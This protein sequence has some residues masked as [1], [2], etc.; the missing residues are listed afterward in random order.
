MNVEPPGEYVPTAHL[1]AATVAEPVP[2]GQK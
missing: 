1:F 2:A